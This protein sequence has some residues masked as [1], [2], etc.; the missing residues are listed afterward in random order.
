MQFIQFGP[1]KIQARKYTISECAFQLFILKRTNIFSVL[2]I[3]RT[4]FLY[5]LH[6]SVSTYV[7]PNVF[8]LLWNQSI[9]TWLMF[10]CRT[11]QDHFMYEHKLHNFVI[12]RILTRRIF[13]SALYSW[14]IFFCYGNSLP[15]LSSQRHVSSSR[16]PYLLIGRRSPPQASHLLQPL[17]NEALAMNK[18]PNNN[19]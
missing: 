14:T 13:I 4:Q 5:I 7:F 11:K 19:C 3:A 12:D 9:C 15:S 2:P 17:T 18:I 8:F 6:S 16:S 10:M 1:S